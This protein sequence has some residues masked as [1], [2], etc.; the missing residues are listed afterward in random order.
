MKDPELNRH[1]DLGSIGLFAYLIGNMLLHGTG[2]GTVAMQIR[3][4][5]C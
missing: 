2:E 1:G 3:D 4:T 5:L